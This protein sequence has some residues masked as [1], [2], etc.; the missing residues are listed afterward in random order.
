MTRLGRNETDKGALLVLLS[1]LTSVADW[2][3]SMN[4]Y[5]H[6]STPHVTPEKYAKSAARQAHRALKALGWLDW[7][8]PQTLLSFEELHGFPPRPAQQEVIELHPGDEEPTLLIAEIA[9]GTGKTELGLYLADRWAVLRQ[10]RG[11]YV[12]MPT[13]A[14][15]NQMYGRVGDYPAQTLSRTT[16]QLSPYS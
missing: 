7:Q 11:L 3:G 15:S 12:A 14:T 13:Q 8:P 2:I 1:G 4:E 10:Q 16:D 6:F 5:F 9:T